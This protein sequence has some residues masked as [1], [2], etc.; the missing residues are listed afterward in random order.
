MTRPDQGLSS[1]TSG[2]G[3]MRDPRNEV[4]TGMCLSILGDPGATSWED[5]IFSGES[6]PMF[7]SSRAPGNLFLPNE[8]QKWKNSVQLIG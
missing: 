2:G 6:L 1:L 5:A 4:G 3:K 8:F 7:K